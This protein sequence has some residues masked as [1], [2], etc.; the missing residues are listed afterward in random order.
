MLPKQ[1]HFKNKQKL[2]DERRSIT[3]IL[4]KRKAKVAILI[5]DKVHFKTNYY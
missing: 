3:L 4:I 1:I 2:K 5:L